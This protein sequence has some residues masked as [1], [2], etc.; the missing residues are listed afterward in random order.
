[1]DAV[2]R[3]NVIKRDWYDSIDKYYWK[4]GRRPENVE[5]NMRTF[6]AVFWYVYKRYDRWGAT[7]ERRE[8]YA[9]ARD[10]RV[11]AYEEMYFEGVKIRINEKLE[12]E[13]VRFW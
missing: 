7:L 12:D 1:M 8:E 4:H 5:M 3:R 11:V 13:V 6:D 9:Y 10:I 2:L